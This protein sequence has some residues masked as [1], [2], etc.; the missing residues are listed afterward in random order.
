MLLLAHCCLYVVADIQAG[1]VI[2]ENN[3]RSIRPGYG[4]A[5]KHYP[6]V[7]SQ[8]AKKFIAK[9]TALQWDMIQSDK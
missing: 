4:L 7:L 3:V 1:E 2:T 5:P 9:G 8:R 6:Q